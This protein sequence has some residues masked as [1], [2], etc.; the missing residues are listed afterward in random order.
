MVRLPRP[1]FALVMLSALGSTGC[2]QALKLVGASLELAAAIA[3]TSSSGPSKSTPC[4][5]AREDPTPVEGAVDRPMSE[6]ELARG[7]Y[8]EAHPAEGD[9]PP[10]LRCTGEGDYPRLAVTT[11]PGRVLL[12]SDG[13]PPLPVSPPPP[14]PS[15]RT[16]A[17]PPPSPPA[18]PEVL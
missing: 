16:S 1:L 14:P 10:A 13:P 17:E 12:P 9:V 15:E 7:R 2:I 6:C 3:R 5:Y 8:R 11:P 18:S 4:C